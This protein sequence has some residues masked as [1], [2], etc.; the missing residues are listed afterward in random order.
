MAVSALYTAATG[1][2][3]LDRKLDVV[4][5]NIANIETVGFKSSRVNFE[6]LFYTVVQAPGQLNAQQEPSP[7]GQLL[8]HGVRVSGTQLDFSQGAALPTENPLDLSIVGDGLFQVITSRDGNDVTAYTRAGNFTLNATG[9]LVLA[10]SVGTRLEPPITIPATATQISVSPQGRVTV[11]DGGQTTEVGTIQLARFVNPAGL[12]PIGKNIYVATPASGDPQTANP[13]EQGLGEIHS[14]ELENSNVDPVKELVTL[15]RTQRAFE[16]NSQV[17]Q[18]SD[19][20]L[21]TVATLRR[22]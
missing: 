3:A 21:R 6:D 17:I 22:V 10:N 19:E 12:E 7:T 8:G 20:V 18:S 15:I 5:N 16:L 14:A 2:N 13:T 1:M 11:V 9:Q 4:A